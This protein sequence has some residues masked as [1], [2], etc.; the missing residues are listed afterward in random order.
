MTQNRT[1][2]NQSPPEVAK[3]AGARPTRPHPPSS[4][5][6]SEAH[7]RRPGQPKGAKQTGAQAPDAAREYG[8]GWCPEAQGPLAATMRCPEPCQVSPNR[9]TQCPPP[10]AS[11][12]RACLSS[13]YCSHACTNPRG[14]K[15]RQSEHRIYRHINIPQTHKHGKTVNVR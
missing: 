10:F 3:Q 4:S 7:R 5:P 15:V 12:N 8:S 14:N 6:T 11:G 1:L 9:S 13:S 2:L